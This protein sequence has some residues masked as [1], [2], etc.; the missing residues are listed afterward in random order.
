[1]VNTL[2]I[3]PKKILEKYANILVNFAL[4]NGK[5]IKKGDTVHLIVPECAKPL[6]V[7]LRKMIL[8]AGGNIILDYR[9]SDDKNFNLSK[10]FYDNANDKQLNFFPARYMRGLINESDHRIIIIS[11]NNKYALKDINPKKIMTRNLSFK[12]FKNWQDKKENIGKFTW[13]LALYGTHAMASEA[14]L[15][16][17]DYWKQITKACFLNEN[18]P[19]KKWK[20][21]YN[22]IE[23]YKNKLNK[24]KIDKLYIKGPDI[25]LIIKI[26]EKKKWIGGDGR[27]IPSFEIFISPDWRGTEGW[28]RF[29]QPL[30]SYGNIVS[31]IEL[32]FKNGKVVKS[33]AKKGEE[34]L[35]RMIETKNADKVGEFSLTD[36]RFS[37]ITK[38]MADTLYD[39]N[40]GG[41]YGNFHIA[42]GNA[43]QDSYDG[44]SS[45]LSKK[46]WARLGFNDSSIHT[47][48]VSTT[49]RTVT[50]YLK[51]G[52]KKVIYKNGK[53]LI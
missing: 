27:N 43:Y 10:D 30:Y 51:N 22:K 45:K 20:N 37:K 38:F 5:G 24:L 1:M 48:I 18:N 52:K 12:S 44:D 25:D 46:D 34:V 49:P 21:I 4:N 7:E 6:L 28:V 40:A 17:K 8:K 50:A 26:G 42:L 9:P 3:P 41:H 2:Y 36:S 19:I 31:G 11:E 35:K 53:F 23:S 13:T 14:K 39:E 33:K 32:E 16:E 15:S 47:D 29:S